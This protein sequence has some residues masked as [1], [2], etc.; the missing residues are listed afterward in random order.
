[1]PNNLP[2]NKTPQTQQNIYT[3]QSQPTKNKEAPRNVRQD[4]R[5]TQRTRIAS[6]QPARQDIVVRAHH[7]NN[8]TERVQ[9]RH[10]AKRR[11]VQITLWVNPIVKAELQRLAEQE[12]L[13]VSAAG[14]AFLEKALQRHVDMQYGALL[15]PIIESA[16]GKQIRSMS[17]RLA[18]LL[19]RIAFDT[20]QT[21]ILATNI[22][23]TQEGMTGDSLKEIL[24]SADKRSK[25]N[26][27][28]KTPQLTELVQAVEKWLLEQEADVEKGGH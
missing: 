6:A 14:G 1:M 5:A 24:N 4:K 10:V 27:T 25:A 2:D 21:R 28:R 17:T 11:T 12:G 23:G 18:W 7:L 9:N 13:S 15:Q 3:N 22:L 19:V 20:G 26:L 16:I 8:N